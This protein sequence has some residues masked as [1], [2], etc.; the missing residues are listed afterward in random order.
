MSV[1]ATDEQVTRRT[2]HRIWLPLTALALA[3]CS[4]GEEPAAPTTTSATTTSSTTAAPPATTSTTAAPTTTEDP[5]AELEEVASAAYLAAVD[6]FVACTDDLDGCDPQ[7]LGEF[8][9]GEALDNLIGTV[10][11]LR[12]QGAEVLPP[13]DPANRYVV[14]EA[15][16]L[17]D[18]SRTEVQVQYCEVDGRRVV[19]PGAGPDGADVVLTD[20]VDAV[21]GVALV[22]LGVDGRWRVTRYATVER[23]TEENV[24]PPP[25]A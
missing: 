15:A 10:E 25:G 1:A 19:Q 2:P 9:A 20:T 5:T 12:G 21:R 7:T 8:N 17:V 16:E 22:E 14:V 24:C 4:S 3:A 18:G 23:S 13:E 11:A 6:A